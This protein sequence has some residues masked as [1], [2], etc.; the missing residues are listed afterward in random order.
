MDYRKFSHQAAVNFVPFS[1]SNMRIVAALPA[2]PELKHSI[3]ILQAMTGINPS[4]MPNLDI[5]SDGKTGLPESVFT[6]EYIAQLRQALT[7]TKEQFINGIV[8]ADMTLTVTDSPY[9]I[10]K[11]VRILPDVTLTI[12]P[13][14]R[15]EFQNRSFGID[16]HLEAN[17]T[18]TT[19]IT[20]THTSDTDTWGGIHFFR[21]LQA[22]SPIRILS[23]RA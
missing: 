4:E 22:V 13:G 19:N 23:I 14:V 6:L 2:L 5:D 11:N 10:T 17:G 18:A 3:S 7:P 16:G 8:L 15:L 12:E 20:F 9:V 21:E 1:D